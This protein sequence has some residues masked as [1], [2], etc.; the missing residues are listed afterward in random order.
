MA[1][2]RVKL[3]TTEARLC[4]VNVFTPRVSTISKNQEAKYSVMLLIPKT[5]KEGILAIQKALAE[6][7]KENTSLFSQSS[8][9]FNIPLKDGDEKRKIEGEFDDSGNPVTTTE[10][11]KK[12]EEFRGHY[13]IS[14]SD[15]AKPTVI[16]QKG[17]VPAQQK[18][19][20]SGCYG[21]AMVTFFPYAKKE[22]RG[23]SAGFT[24]LLIT[25]DGESLEG[26]A[27]EAEVMN[28]FASFIK[29]VSDTDLM[30]ELMGL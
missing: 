30:N 16:L 4:Y 7:K 13:Y 9:V 3:V 18:D 25:K 23:I 8:A 29:P 6:V 22:S 12:G 10:Y 27:S 11:V 14:L 24:G 20:Y 28:E 5:D 17:G 19:V 1:V 26:G 2:H 21:R 15:L